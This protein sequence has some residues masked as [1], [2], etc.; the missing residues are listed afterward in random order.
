MKKC[1]GF[2]ALCLIFATNAQAQTL[3]VT[4]NDLMRLRPQTLSVKSGENV[5]IVFKNVGKISSLKHQFILLKAGIDAD[6][7]GNSL[8]SSG[9]SDKVP[10]NLKNQV[11]VHSA[12]LGPG[13]EATLSFTAPAPGTYT[14]LCGFPGHHSAARGTLKVE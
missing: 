7:F 8:L 5:T 3:E 14:Y 6:A 12:Q 10:A 4:A 2:L 13:Q 11:I 9:A 1:F